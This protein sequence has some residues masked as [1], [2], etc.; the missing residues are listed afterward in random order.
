[1][2]SKRILQPED[3]HSDIRRMM[4][5]VCADC[6]TDPQ[7]ETILLSLLEETARDNTDRFRLVERSE[8]D[9]FL[10]D[11]TRDRFRLPIRISK[12]P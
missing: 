11:R 6:A 12:C 9:G 2:P 7:L 3:T 1:M 10:W 5:A 8:L 4:L